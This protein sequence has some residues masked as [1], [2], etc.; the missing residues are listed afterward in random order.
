MPFSDAQVRLWAAAAHNESIA[1]KKGVSRKQ[2]RR[3]LMESPKKQRKR[4]MSTAL[5]P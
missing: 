1:K 2:A 3:M 4:A 5:R